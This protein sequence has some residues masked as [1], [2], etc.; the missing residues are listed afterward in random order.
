MRLGYIRTG[1]AGPSQEEQE[2]ALRAAGVVDFSADGPVYVDLV[3]RKRPKPGDDVTPA[4]TAL[5]VALREGD[6]IAIHSAPRLGTTR[7][8]VLRTLAQIGK[9]GA[10]VYDCELGEVVRYHPDAAAALLFADRAEAQ[11]KRERAARARKAITHRGTRPKA[12]TGK[13]LD[14]ARELWTGSPETSAEKIADML[15]VSPR[16]LYRALGERGTPKFGRQKP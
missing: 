13:K 8:D 14:K 10:A 9:A 3:S 5:I 7:E 6:E 1:Q 15:G 2:A 16:T 12:L 4:R 11:G